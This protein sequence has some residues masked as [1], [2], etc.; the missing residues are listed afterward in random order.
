M[1]TWLDDGTIVYVGR[2][3][4]LRRI[5]AAGGVSRQVGDTASLTLYLSLS[6]LP[7]SRGFLFTACGGDGNCAVESAV[8]VFDFD[9]DSARLLVPNAAGAWYSPTGHLVYTHRGGG[10]Y[11]AR[12]D[13]GRMTLT[14]SA[15]PIIENVVPVSFT[16]SASGAALYSTSTGGRSP[17]QLDWVVRDGSAVPLDS[18]WRGNFQFP[19]LSPD[20]QT[21]AVSVGEASTQLWLRRSD[22]TRQK[23]TD[24]GTIN[25]RPS[26]TA[27]GRSLLF[28]SNRRGGVQPFDLLQMPADAS[29]AAKVV[30]H[31][32]YS[33]WEGEISRDGHWLAVR[34]DE[35]L[36]FGN[37]YAR[38]LVGDTTLIPIQV[39]A[40][41]T[42][43]IALSPDG[44][45]I[46]F[47]GD[48]TGRLEI[49]VAP[50]PAGKPAVLVSRDGGSEPRWAS[51]GRELFYK[52]GGWLMSVEIAPGGA[53]RPGIPKPLFSVAPY[54]SSV[55]RQQ[56][57]VSADGSHFV[58]IRDLTATAT[59][60][61]YVENWLQELDARVKK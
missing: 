30:Q 42:R 1:A 61:V 3:S 39:D 32:A 40:S 28:S 9:A 10:L 54:R 2:R 19:A 45:W 5:D 21:L 46:V 31:R 14:S 57:D 12:F 60:V 34:F 26:W 49:Y 16:M 20:G 51:S 47:S 7:A 55:S 43:Q 52:S 27:D 23:L 25:W 18:A 41:K 13:V 22:G 17:A 35:P 36:T 58:M 33:A 8:Y 59:D 4:G 48:A 24:E 56:Y 37:L 15:V 53:L 11:A 29:V 6:P 44:R 38:R 50:F